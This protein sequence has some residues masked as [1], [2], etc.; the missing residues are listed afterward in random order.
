MKQHNRDNQR[1]RHPSQNNPYQQ[2]DSTKAVPSVTKWLLPILSRRL[3]I[4]SRRQQ[5]LFLLGCIVAILALWFLTPV[6]DSCAAFILYTVPIESDVALGREALV[7]LERKY[8]R[9]HDRWGVSRIG[10]ELVSAGTLSKRDLYS[11]QLQQNPQLFDNIEIYQWDFGVVKAP[12]DMVNAFALPGG[13]V[14][15]TDSL[16]KTLHLTDAELA[17]LLGHEMGHILYRHS[18]KRAIKNHL[19]STI[20]E[21]FSYED[22]D[23]YNESFGEAVAEGMWKSASFL[24]ELAFS[25]S[26]EY[27]ADEAAW[28]LLASTYSTA[29]RSNNIDA[30]QFHPKSVKSLLT[31]LWK[32]QGGSG[33]TSWESTHP[34]TK[35]RIDALQKKWN[36]LDTLKRR[37]FV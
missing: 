16:L 25:R 31:K 23:G 24:G 15:V 17:A 2:N 34:G 9:V 32:Y 27:Q 11:R 13:I 4:K 8:P 14:R 10:S 6:S 1:R 33:S 21:A 19:L 20:W 35:D 5:E 28:D 3:G 7:S 26:D 30:R 12:P 22:N 29:G 37:T 36:T 18:Q